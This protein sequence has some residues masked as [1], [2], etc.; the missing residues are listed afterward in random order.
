MITTNESIHIKLQFTT[1][2]FIH[3]INISK[4]R[5]SPTKHTR[6]ATL[7]EKDLIDCKRTFK[8]SVCIKLSHNCSRINILHKIN[9][10]I[11][12]F[13]GM[14]NYTSNTIIFIIFSKF[15]KLRN[16]SICIYTKWK[17]SC[18]NTILFL[19]IFKFGSNSTSLTST[20]TNALSYFLS[21]YNCTTSG[22][23]RSTINSIKIRFRIKDKFFQRSIYFSK[24]KLRTTGRETN[25][26]TLTA[27]NQR[28]ETNR[29]KYSWNLFGIIIV[30]IPFFNRI[31]L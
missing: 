5:F 7:I 28:P 31:L 13:L 15:S 20:I 3:V 2:T 4:A 16:Y 26:D 24:I 27:I 11:R 23:I 30:I 17:F 1:L 14:I 19:Y 6:I 10:N 22:K 8:R 18:L 25:R 29:A 9:T 12:R 21:V